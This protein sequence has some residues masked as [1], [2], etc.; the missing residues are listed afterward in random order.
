MTIREITPTIDT[1]TLLAGAQFA[2]PVLFGRIVDVLSGKEDERVVRNGHDKLTVFGI[3]K[4]LDAAGW[5]ALYRQLAAAGMLAGDDEGHGTLLL[6]DR[7]RPLLRGEEKFAMRRPREAEA[8]K[9]KAKREGRGTVRAPVS[10]ADEAP[11]QALRALRARLAAEAKLPPY[12]IFHDAT[13]AELAAKR[14]ASLDALADISGLGTSKIKRYGDA[15]L[16]T[17][18]GAKPRHA[19]LDNRLS[20]TVNATLALHLDG[21]DIDKIAVQRGLEAGTVYGHLAEAIEAGLV[22]ARQVIGLDEAEVDEIMAVF[23]RL[24]TVDSGKLG[25]AHAALDG[26]YAYGLL[27][28]LLA[29]LA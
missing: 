20:A 14:P 3:G 5:R 13:L 23:E 15:I 19:K 27:K 2:E 10:A 4:D 26:R 17:L 18:G 9:G 16:E 21:L 25:P 8:R 28:C 6:T 7:A 22:E 29:E 12:V 11:Y 1:D 24:G